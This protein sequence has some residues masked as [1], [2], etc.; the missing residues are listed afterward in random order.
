MASSLTSTCFDSFLKRSIMFGFEI[1]VYMVGLFST[2]LVTDLRRRLKLRFH[3]PLTNS[4]NSLV[5]WWL[6][7]PRAIFETWYPTL[8]ISTFQLL[9]ETGLSWWFLRDSQHPGLVSGVMLSGRT[10]WGL[11]T[12]LVC[13]EFPVYVAFGGSY[14][15]IN[16]VINLSS[17]CR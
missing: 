17:C 5:C 7:L 1:A 12:S 16:I 4:P 9:A 15:H 2:R 11:L 14:N 6:S 8:S 13:F 10:V 3:K